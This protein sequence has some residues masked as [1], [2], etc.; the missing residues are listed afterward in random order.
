[1]KRLSVWLRGVWSARTS[2]VDELDF[3]G[4]RV[5][6]ALWSW[7]LL[8]GGVVAMMSAVD[9]M[10]QIERDQV[11]AQQQFRRLSLADRQMRLKR[12]IE[13]GPSSGRSAPGV[14]VS[15]VAPLRGAGLAHGLSMARL[16]AYPWVTT[17]NRIE[18]EAAAH[19]VVLMAMSVDLAKQGPG[20]EGAPLW[21]LQAAVRDDASALAWTAR[22]PGGR[23]LSRERLAQGFSAEAGAYTL[24]IDAQMAGWGGAP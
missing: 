20:P 23:M 7:V 18:D 24:K 1:M 12:A 8:A 21:R 3:V 13:Q 17:L 5:P 19:Q 16:L 10:E 22:L 6:T 2:W 9:V 14:A 11:D 15:G 4:P